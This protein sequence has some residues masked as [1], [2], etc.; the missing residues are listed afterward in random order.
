LESNRKINIS[1]PRVF[2]VHFRKLVSGDFGILTWLPRLHQLHYSTTSLLRSTS[3]AFS[4]PFKPILERFDRGGDLPPWCVG[5]FAGIFMG[6]ILWVCFGHD[7]FKNHR[8]AFRDEG[9]LA[10]RQLG[11]QRQFQPL[12]DRLNSSQMMH[13]NKIVVPS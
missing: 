3:I 8:L 5:S 2:K 1:F 9:P 11:E 7:D 6:L 13:G 4:S 12:D 10:A